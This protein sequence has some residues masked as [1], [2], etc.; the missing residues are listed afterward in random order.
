M[1]AVNAILIPHIVCFKK[2]KNL[3]Y[4]WLQHLDIVLYGLV[5]ENVDERTAKKKKKEDGDEEGSGE[6]G[7][8]GSEE[9]GED[10]DEDLED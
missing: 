9:D 7:E 4:H 3:V 5:L 2:K 10:M 8:E 6:E 1:K